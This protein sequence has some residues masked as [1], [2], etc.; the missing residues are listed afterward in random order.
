[1]ANETIGHLTCPHC[2]NPE[3]T[4]HR[5][6]RGKHSLYYRCYATPNSVQMRCGTVQIHGPKGQEWIAAN[7]RP[8]AAN[9]PKAPEPTPEPT[10]E[11]KAPEP[12]PEKRRSSVFGGFL[13][14][15]S[16]EDD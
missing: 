9:E 10:P 1:M 4:V 13:A 12:T 8:V 11:P 16:K 7:M 5:Q 3:A 15:L 2:G 6:A 14:S